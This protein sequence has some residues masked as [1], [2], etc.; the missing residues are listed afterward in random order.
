MS[1]LKP[2][3]PLPVV[4]PSEWSRRWSTCVHGGWQV[5][6]IQPTPGSVRVTPRPDGVTVTIGDGPG[7]AP[8]CT[9]VEL[10]VDGRVS[11]H[12][13]ASPPCVLLTP[14][15]VRILPEG[16]ESVGTVDL[17]VG[18]RLLLMS[19]EALGALP[20]ALSTMRRSGTPNLDAD[21]P[22]D[23]L[24]RLLHDLPIGAAAVATRSRHAQQLLRKWGV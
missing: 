22:G 7:S 18:D 3:T 21:G 5:A 12:T 15:A 17:D 6:S 4:R 11:A 1:P 8:W 19:A 23:L 2:A 13:C 14:Q 9:T 16:P 20:E 10:D 24:R